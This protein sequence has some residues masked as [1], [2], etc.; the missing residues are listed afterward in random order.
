MAFAETLQ[1]DLFRGA[2]FDDEVTGFPEGCAGF[3]NLD[4][5]IF[6]V[7]IGETRRGA[8]SGFDNAFIAQLL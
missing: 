3:H 6:V 8:C 4:T 2:D 5:S 1:L 7:L